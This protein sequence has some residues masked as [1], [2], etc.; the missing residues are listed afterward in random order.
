MFDDKKQ[1][2]ALSVAVVVA[3]GLI[4]LIVTT[5][6]GN[7]AVSQPGLPT[8]IVLPITPLSGGTAGGTGVT[9]G[10]AQP[11]QAGN[12]SG[13]IPSVAAPN[14]FLPATPAA[15]ANN[16]FIA[17]GGGAFVAAGTPQPPQ[18]VPFTPIS[19]S[20]NYILSQIPQSELTYSGPGAGLVG[21]STIAAALQNELALMNATSGGVAAII[22]SL[23]NQV[24]AVSALSQYVSGLS[25][26]A[27]SPQDLSLIISTLTNSSGTV[28]SADFSGAVQRVIAS[29]TRTCQ[30]VARYVNSLPSSTAAL[31]SPTISQCGISLPASQ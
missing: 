16:G 27:I 8:P 18:S 2:I 5:R 31:F 26:T 17:V 13:N 12:V 21:S 7:E 15:S 20:N 3:I 9:G 28:S 30:D 14:A 10:M 11:G 29:S 1:I 25:A 6:R 24:N 22:G 4:V 23:Q 19:I